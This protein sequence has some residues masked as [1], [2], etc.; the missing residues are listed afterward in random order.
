MPLIAK[1]AKIE[2]QPRQVSQ[3]GLVLWYKFN[4]AGY[5]AGTPRLPDSAAL[6]LHRAEL[7]TGGAMTFDGINDRAEYAHRA[8]LLL[9]GSFSIVFAVNVSSS[10]TNTNPGILNFGNSAAAG[11]GGTGW[12]VDFGQASTWAA[13]KADVRLKWN[14]NNYEASNVLTQDTW[15]SVAIAYDG[16]TLAIYVDGVIQVSSAVDLSTAPRTHSGVLMLGA[17]DSG[18]F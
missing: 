2:V 9:P 5:T 12:A 10:Q 14:C 18:Q 8:A 16:S 1:I 7:Y 11:G 13:G 4:Q 6:A 15:H 17:G 3:E